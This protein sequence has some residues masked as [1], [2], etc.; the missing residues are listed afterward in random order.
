MSAP[1]SAVPTRL[2]PQSFEGQIEG[3]MR[4]MLR[5]M[6]VEESLLAECLR[7]GER[8]IPQW[9]EITATAKQQ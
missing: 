2:W 3:G 1:C 4:E 7:R 6:R 5:L 8:R 9:N